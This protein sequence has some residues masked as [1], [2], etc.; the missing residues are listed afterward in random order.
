MNEEEQNKLSRR[1]FFKKASK[2]GLGVAGTLFLGAKPVSGSEVPVEQTVNFEEIQQR[3]NEY[4]REITVTAV[5]LRSE[6]HLRIARITQQ[7]M[8]DIQTLLRHNRPDLVRSDLLSE[9]TIEILRDI[10]EI[11][12]EAKVNLSGTVTEVARDEFRQNGS[13]IQASISTLLTVRNPEIERNDYYNLYRDSD[14][15]VI[16]AETPVVVEGYRI[17]NW[18][19]VSSLQELR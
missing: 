17:D 4:N 16:R 2:I 15:R 13:L 3:I 18:I 1:N 9:N 10:P 8:E 11:S 7:R 14:Q 5:N 19:F 12:I 6:D